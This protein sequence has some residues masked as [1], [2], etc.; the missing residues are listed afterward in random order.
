[1]GTNECVSFAITDY[2]N[3]LRLELKLCKYSQFLEYMTIARVKFIK[4]VEYEELTLTEAS[5]FP[6]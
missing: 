4:Y 5:D 2:A 6:I 1:M 3:Q